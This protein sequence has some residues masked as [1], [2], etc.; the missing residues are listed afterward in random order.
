MYLLPHHITPH[1]ITHLTGA[2]SAADRRSH[3]N[4]AAAQRRKQP[5]AAC[6][7]MSS[8]PIMSIH[9]MRLVQLGSLGALHRAVILLILGN[10]VNVII[11]ARL[12]LVV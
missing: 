6:I 5:L 3:C 11:V 2:H 10:L 12:G 9:P 7:A 8:V 4:I 1:L